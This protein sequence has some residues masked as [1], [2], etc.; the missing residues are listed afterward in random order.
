MKKQENL[1]TIIQKDETIQRAIDENP[2]LYHV[3]S[4]IHDQEYDRYKGPIKAYDLVDKFDKYLA[5]GET[6][7]RMPGPGPNMYGY[8]ALRIPELAAKGLTSLY[9][10][11]KTGDWKGVGK[12]AAMET[13]A[14][15]APFGESVNVLPA[16]RNTAKGMLLE[17]VR[18]KFNDYL[19]EG[20]I[21]EFPEPYERKKAA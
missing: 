7:L 18:K 16:Y 12:L 19:S 2:D 17:K 3:L 13:A 5:V 10:G 20:K 6:L 9:Y 1:E 15:L 11:A 4:S 8:A 14:T 21:I